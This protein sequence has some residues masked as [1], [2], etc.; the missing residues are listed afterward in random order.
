MLRTPRHPPLHAVTTT[1]IRQP[2]K[3]V[4]L[5]SRGH[6]IA[7]RWT[8][9][10]RLNPYYAIGREVYRV[11]SSAAALPSVPTSGG[12]GGA[13]AHPGWRSRLWIARVS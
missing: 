6:L 4:H 5:F 2:R 9:L 3:G 12:G 7:N 11:K 8:E 13:A 10:D 1:A